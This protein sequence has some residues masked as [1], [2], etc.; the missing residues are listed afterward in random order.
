MTF[1]L[2]GA[3]VRNN[4]RRS[5][6]SDWRRLP[7]RTSSRRDP[8]RHRVCGRLASWLWA[9]SSTFR[10]PQR[11]SSSGSV[12]RRLWAR[13]SRWSPVRDPISGGTACT[14]LCERLRSLRL[15]SWS[16][17]AGTLVSLSA[18][19]ARQSPLR[20]P[21][22]LP[23]SPPE[24]VRRYCPQHLIIFPQLLPINTP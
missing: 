8:S 22:V 1:G 10:L 21:Q 24:P 6:G 18:G 17:G 12:S 9:A 23:S 3:A 4:L 15:V 7:S 20:S 13:P 19:T 2:E 11:P 16:R 14:L 5:G